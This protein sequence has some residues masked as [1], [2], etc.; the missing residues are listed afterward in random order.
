[1]INSKFNLILDILK[2][3]DGSIT[4]DPCFKI[5]DKNHAISL[6]K[7]I[8]EIYNELGV[9]YTKGYINQT[10]LNLPLVKAL[11]VKLALIK[12]PQ[13]FLGSLSLNAHYYNLILLI[14]YRL[15]NMIEI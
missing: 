9:L 5:R 10:G 14:I 2:I 6:I 12:K 1:M 3:V 7:D 4:I 11:L 15:L 13:D 8:S